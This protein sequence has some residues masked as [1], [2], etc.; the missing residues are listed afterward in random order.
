MALKDRIARDNRNIFMNTDHV[1]EEHTWNGVKFTCV[2][3]DTTTKH[4]QFNSA[5]QK[6]IFVPE[7]SLP[8]RA[9]PNE[10]IILDNVQ[11]RVLDVIDADGMKEILLEAVY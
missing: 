3:D 5:T 4:I 9:Q 6:L 10:F 11:M 8:G 2:P 1:A 7:N